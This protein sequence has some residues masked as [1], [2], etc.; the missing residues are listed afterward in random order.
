MF[1]VKRNRLLRSSRAHPVQSELVHDNPVY[2]ASV[3]VFRKGVPPL[4]DPRSLNQIQGGV[5]RQPAAKFA[6]VEVMAMPAD[7]APAIASDPQP[8]AAPSGPINRSD[9]MAS[10]QRLMPMAAA[11]RRKP[12]VAPNSPPGALE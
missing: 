9:G 4:R 10:V 5:T 11:M 7:P 8:A 1:T 2:H 3:N 6:R 12:A